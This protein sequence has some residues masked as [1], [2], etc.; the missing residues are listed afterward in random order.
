[1]IRGVT[2]LGVVF[3]EAQTT[4]GTYTLEAA[5]TGTVPSSRVRAKFGGNLIVESEYERAKVECELH[6]RAA[7]RADTRRFELYQA[8]LAQLAT[9]DMSPKAAAQRAWALVSEALAEEARRR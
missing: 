4:S 5:A 1:M 7:E 8:C 6:A 9:S 2:E 3:E